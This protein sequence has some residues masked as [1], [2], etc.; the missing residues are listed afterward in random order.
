[1]WRRNARAFERKEAVAE[2]AWAINYTKRSRD[3]LGKDFAFG[4]AHDRPIGVR[5]VGHGL[6][7]GVGTGGNV[8]GLASNHSVS[9]GTMAEGY[10]T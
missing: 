1:M 7:T 4:C 3:R 5:W 10:G 2:K 8:S 9:P 6:A